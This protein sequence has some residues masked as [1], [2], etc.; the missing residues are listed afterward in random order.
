MEIMGLSCRLLLVCSLDYAQFIVAR[1]SAWKH[2]RCD[3]RVR[4]ST[5]PSAFALPTGPGIESLSRIK[6]TV[7]ETKTNSR[8][9][10]HLHTDTPPPCLPS[11]WKHSHIQ[12]SSPSSPSW[13]SPRN[14]CSTTSSQAR[15]AK[16]RHTS[17]MPWY[18]PCS[19]A[20]L[21]HAT[22]TRAAS[23]T[24]GT[25]T[26]KPRMSVHVSRLRPLHASGIAESAR[27]QSRHVPTTARSASGRSS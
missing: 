23:R 6:N 1:L 7:P 19:S 21:A 13:P 3:R 5:H 2:I 9:P 4:P 11:A 20:T 24:T 27:C 14:G 17:S 12:V 26:S 15:C 8:R 10:L 18:S 16:A 22:Q 25:K